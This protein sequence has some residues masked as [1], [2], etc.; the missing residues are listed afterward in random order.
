MESYLAG[1]SDSNGQALTEEDSSS[2][3]SYLEKQPELEPTL[4]EQFEDT[5]PD[6]AEVGETQVL[7]EE[8]QGPKVE[9]VS[10]DGCPVRI[11]VFLES[12]RR[13]ELNCEY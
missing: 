11:I 5:L 12:G 7:Y 2:F 6:P 13:L 9:V 3:R 1:R 4:E 8:E 10:V